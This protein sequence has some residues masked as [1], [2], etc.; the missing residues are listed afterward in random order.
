[1]TT[2]N[3]E[4]PLV[5][6][7]N[8]Q[9]FIDFWRLC[10]PFWISKEKNTALVM[11]ALNIVCILVGVWT[12]IGINHFNK[13]FYDALGNFDKAAIL[14]ALAHFTVLLSILILSF[15]YSTYFTMQIGIRW[16]RWL[17][18]RYQHQWLE[19]H[20]HYHMQIINKNIDN[21]DQRISD[22]LQLLTLY[23]LNIFFNV[24]QSLLTLG[25]FGV[26]LWG[27]SGRMEIPIGSMRWV[28]PGYL[29]WSALIFAALGTYLM[30]KIGR[31][32]SFLNY[33]Q[34]KFSADF[35]FSLVRLRE[36]SEQI[37]MSQGEAVEKEKLSDLF[38]RIYTNYLSIIGLQKNLVFFSNGYNNIAA[39]I[40]I[41]F[42]MPLYLAKKIQL[43]G[44]MQISGA[45]GAVISA[46]SVFINSFYQLTEW[47]A[48]IHRLTEFNNAMDSL[49]NKP[50]KSIFIE[51]KEIA[52]IIIQDLNLTR[53]D[54]SPLLSS[55]NLVLKRGDSVLLSGPS[56]IGKSTL[57]RALAGV[58]VYGSGNIQLPTLAN[59]V[60][61]PQKPY[62][63][64]G[65][66]KEALLYPNHGFVDDETLQDILKKCLLDKFLDDLNTVN[67]WSHILSLGEQQRLA[68]G[69]I[70]LNLPDI[71]CLDESTSALDEE[72]ES[73]LY[74]NMKHALPHA[75][76]ISV[77]H[78]PNLKRFHEKIVVLPNALVS[79]S[80]ILHKHTT[81]ELL[82][83]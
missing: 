63:P 80:E 16:Q 60:F 3:H 39:I 13:T 46:F 14:S 41:L 57:L 50:Q 58:W 65:T 72:K 79:Q 55:M 83:V 15:G 23:T 22:D 40:G 81:D 61:I 5:L 82:V 67:H 12:T 45:F 54:G 44:L 74:A 68:F 73:F 47:R 56:G 71:I 42:S 70:F 37:A 25:S 7:F 29:C 38:R 49:Q 35:R 75:T 34:Q 66:L 77:S 28:I 31:K 4:S 36:A 1:M 51:K 27:L 64:L 6:R 20:T 17:T 18:Q 2:Q 11:L 33:Q 48:V 59:I 52:D 10:K 26:I 21:P 8:R 69:R 32:L 78:H 30:S 76:I 53:P 19:N 24:F 9:F 62:L 43:G